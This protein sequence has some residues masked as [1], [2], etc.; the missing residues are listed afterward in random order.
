MIAEKYVAKKDYEKAII[1][2]TK[3][4]ELETDE[5]LNLNNYYERGGCYYYLKQYDNS[6]LDFKHCI[7][8]SPTDY[9]SYLFLGYSY[10]SQGKKLDACAIFNKAF[11]TN[12]SI[13]KDKDTRENILSAINKYCK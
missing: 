3:S 4:I 2:F 11:E 12:E 7:L 5:M 10:S 1:F 9:Q 13:S 8:I 6:I